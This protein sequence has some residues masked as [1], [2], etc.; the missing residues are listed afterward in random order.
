MAE[1]PPVV[2]LNLFH[3]G[4]GIVRQLTRHGIRVLGLSADR[5][6]YGNFTRLCEV[7]IAPSSQEHPDQLA[8]FLMNIATDF[9]GA[10]VFPTNDFDLMFLDA[11]RD[12]LGSAYKLAIPERNVLVQ[13]MDKSVLYAV[14]LRAG[15]PVPRTIKINSEAELQVAA[16]HVG[17][18]SVLKPVMSTDWRRADR[19]KAV[20]R[21]KALRCNNISEL[22]G[23]YQSV[24]R[25]QSDSL[26]QEWIPGDESRLCTWAGY[27]GADSQVLAHFTA[28]KLMESPGECGTGCLVESLPM[29]ELVPPSTRICHALNYQ[30]IAEIEFKHDARDGSCKLI[31]INPRH[32]DWH[33]LGMASNVNFSLLAYKYLAGLPVHPETP[34]TRSST[35]VAEDALLTEMLSSMAKGAIAPLKKLQR[36]PRPRIY[37]IFSRRDPMP[38]LR[39][40]LATLLPSYLK[41]AGRKAL[42]KT[43]RRG[44]HN[45]RTRVLSTSAPGRSQERATQV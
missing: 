1:K 44:K 36:S 5:Q 3:S 12:A 30:G 7:R 31:E 35:W 38:F 41:A 11:F 16:S 29:P 2:V 27:L 13:I 14:A 10:V 43:K 8:T 18:P 40:G 37:S 15:V 34:L 28:R 6:I 21:R 23:Q 45:V 22:R 24:S 32:W 9:N 19:W 20:G 25:V 42:Q 39:Y 4:L 33:Q 17:F 26:L